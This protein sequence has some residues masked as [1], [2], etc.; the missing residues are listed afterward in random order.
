MV[1]ENAFEEVKPPAQANDAR[2]ALN[3]RETTAKFL[4]A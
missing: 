1:A 2:K 3:T 4:A